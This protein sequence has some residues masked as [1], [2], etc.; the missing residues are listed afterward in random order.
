MLSCFPREV[1]DEILNLIESVSED[2]PTYFYHRQLIE[3]VSNIQ[4]NKRAMIRNQYKFHI[5]FDSGINT[6]KFHIPF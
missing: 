6:I 1:L 5:P 4:V 3:L 2:F